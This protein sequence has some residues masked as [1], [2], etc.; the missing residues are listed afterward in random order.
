MEKRSSHLLKKK[1]DKL[2]GEA[3]KKQVFTACSVGFFKK[4]EKAIEGDFFNYGLA[5]DDQLTFPVDDNTFFDLASLT[6]PLV[7]SLSVLALL[8]EGKV[9]MG[10]K[11]EFFFANSLA[12][13]KKITLLHLLTHSSGLP[14]HR[15]Y[16]KKLVPILYAE[17]KDRI[18]DWILAENLLFKP[19]TENLYS[20]LG[21][22]LLGRIIEKISGKSLDEYWE[23]KIITP[24]GLNKGLF[25]ASQRERDLVVCAPTGTCEWSK[26]KLC[27]KVHDDNCRVLGGVAG[28]AGLFGS[29]NAVLSLCENI[30]QQFQGDRQHPSYSSENLRKVLSDKHGRWVFGFDTPTAGFSS[31]G[32]HFSDL[33]IGHLGFTGT[34]FWI[35]LQR[36]IAIVFLTN[37]VNCGESLTPIKRLRPLLHDTIM[38]FLVPYS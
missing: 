5:G 28:H 4:N 25:F 11:I 3:L 23:R 13:K 22:I 20:D 10:E 38:E 6:K 17:R 24:L 7:T 19:G 2:L 21:F 31:S 34:S 14:A 32:K 16:Y 8:E 12:G 15:P 30:V 37:R 26:S 18:I 1:I 9:N 27:G 29:A 36:G 33:T 35:D